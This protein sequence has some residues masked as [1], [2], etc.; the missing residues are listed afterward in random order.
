MNLAM[1]SKTSPAKW[2]RDWRLGVILLLGFLLIAVAVNWLRYELRSYALLTHFTDPEATGPILRWESRQV[3]TED[4]P[5]STSGEPIP[6]RLYKPAGISR[7]PGMVIAHGIHHLGINEPRLVNFARAMAGTG[8]EVLTPELTSLADYHVD[9][10][11][12]AAIG[13]S[14]GWLDQHL[15]NRRVTVTGV[16]FAGG[17]ALLAAC[18]PK[19]APHFKA[20]VLMGAYAD[21]ARA[22][23]FLVTDEEE[24]PDGRT[25]KFPAHPYG[26]QVLVYARLDKFFPPNDLPA[27]Y[28]AL[29]YWLWEQPEDARSWLAKLSPA[30]R[31]TMESL[32]N[33]QFDTLRPKMLVAIRADQPQ[34]DAISPHGRI[35]GLRIPVFILHGTADDIIP[36]SESAWLQREVPPADLRAAL[37]TP[38]FSHVDAKKS[39]DW[40]EKLRLVQF[41]AEVLRATN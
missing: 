12:I 6:G 9:A 21:L 22:S 26:A 20:L 10:A 29:R 17:L 16:S 36:A 3:T 19:Y 38:V 4:V 28:E 37:I 34:L 24:F 40:W 32:F 39:G 41:I 30:S 1:P 8:I 27:A 25:L 2:R 33:R 31:T 7:P 23:R 5:I 11:S 35:A 14:A 15:G 13:E 18:D